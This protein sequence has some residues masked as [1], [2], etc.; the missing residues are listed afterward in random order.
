MAARRVFF[1]VQHLLGI[2]H[3]RRA[4]TIARALDTAGLDVMVVSGGGEVPGLNIGGATLVQL[5]ATRAADLYF[6]KLLDETGAPIDDAW[7][8]QRRDALLAAFEAFEPH[9]CM[10][11]LFP[12]GRRQMRFELMPV[13]DAAI[14]RAHRPSIVSSVRDILVAQNKPGRNDEMLDL[15]G[16]YF[17]HIVVHGDPACIGFERTFP[18]A[19]RIADK[20]RYTG[21]VV[22]RSGQ[23]T[24]SSVGTDEVIV[25]AGGGAVGLELLRAAIAARPMTALAN[26]TWRVLIGVN[27]PEPDFESLTALASGNV[28]VERARGDFP[29]LAA[30]CALSIS[31]GGYNTMMELLEGGARCVIVPYAGGIETEQTLRA[32]EIAK[33]TPVQVLDETNLS[34][35]A[36]ARAADA[37][38]AAPA[39]DNRAID[40]QGATETARLVRAWADAVP[41]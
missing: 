11:E 16:R 15:V 5:N 19:A 14:A 8:A 7:R 39:P 4:A 26:R 12:F 21:Y 41:W 6:K 37:A 29:T 38:M 28:V 25:S 34:P 27:V 31:Q 40:T 1:Y 24:P 3:L 13:L 36:L 20:I 35:E 22:D 23:A 33:R 30:N 10:F 9:V 17:D 18:Y 2:G 32:R